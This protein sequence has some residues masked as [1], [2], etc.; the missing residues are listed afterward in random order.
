MQMEVESPEVEMSIDEVSRLIEVW[1]NEVSNAGEGEE[2]EENMQI[3][4]E[5]WDDVHGGELPI[6]DVKA[7]RKDETNY[8]TNR[9]IW[10]EVP[11]GES[12]E[13]TG[14]GRVSVSWVDVNNGGA[15]AMVVRCRLVARDLRAKR[16][17][18]MICLLQHLHWR[19]RGC[20]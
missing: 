2:Y 9:K 5:A 4:Q 11:I 1:V 6:E 17:A 13:K 20:Y 3:M 15:G 16:R 8:M 19:R 14:K 7:A 12:L 18:E 10:S